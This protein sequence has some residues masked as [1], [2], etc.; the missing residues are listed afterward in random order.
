MNII[1]IAT[2]TFLIA[3]A[4]LIVGLSS[5][6]RVSEI[7]QPT[8]PQ[9]REP[10]GEIAIG[11]VL[12]LTGRLTESFG[13]PM[14]HGFELALNEINTAHPSGAKLK[15]I[16]ED[17]GSTVEGAVK[18][19]SKLI[20]EEGVFVILGPAT[21]SQT[22]KA[23]QIAQENQVVAMSPTSAA[24]GLSAIGDYVFRVALVTDVLT[25]SGIEATQTKL[26]YQ[27]AATL[28]DESDLFSTDADAALQEVLAAN[29][30][31]VLITETFQGGSDTD[32]TE[33]LTRIHALNPDI[34]FVSSLP[35]EKPGILMQGHQLGIST[36]FIVR[37]LTGADVQAAGAAAE[38]ALT[39]IGWGTAINTPGNQTFV[40]HYRDIYG[41]EPNN[42]AA[43]SYATLHILAAAIA[44]AQSADAASIRDALANIRDFDT[45]F[46]KF[47]FNANG[48]AVYDAKV[49]IVKDGELVLFE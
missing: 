40:Q 10:S 18:A 25:R 49:L 17:D 2:F 12:P 4:A 38:G 24:R 37:T 23:F 41:M 8:T 45:I 13:K 39:F 34:V 44:N 1:K 21:S 30:V 26:G 35:P 48:D 15:L 27:K 3:I 20:H 22:E 33:Q 31:E 32:F 5:C 14:Q 43:R 29:G 46:G 16:V 9:M 36:P 42:Y 11:V 6:D 47:S 7:V 19:F 28:H